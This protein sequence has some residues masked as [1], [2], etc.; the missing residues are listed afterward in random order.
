M[1]KNNNLKDFV[2][3]VANAIRNKKK[4][5]N[6]INPQD[7]ETEIETIQT[8]V[9]TS[10]ATATA[11]DIR[12][13]KTAYVASG[14]VTGTI[15]D[16]D[17]SSEPASGKSLFAQ[18]VD[19][20][21]TEVSASDLASVSMI[22][23]YAFAGCGSLTNVAI[24]SNIKTIG[25][26]AFKECNSLKSIAIPANVNRIGYEAFASCSSLQKII[27]SFG[28]T[29]IDSSAFRY[30]RSLTSILIPDSVTVMKNG[31]FEYC[32]S[33]TNVTLSNSITTIEDTTFSNCKSMQNII[34]PSGVISIGYGAFRSAGLTDITIPEGVT[35]I[36]SSAFADDYGLASVMIPSTMTKIDSYAFQNCGKNVESGIT[37]TVLATIPPTI[38]GSG[39]FTKT[40]LNKIIV[41][42]GTANTYKAATNWSAFADYIEE[43]TV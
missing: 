2:T 18:R 9:D 16:Y 20:S 28:V 37:F 34:I 40:Y 26:Y 31:M 6:L 38:V 43:A 27:I 4:T 41:P 11:D 33:L 17:G 22:S 25:S 39:V 36:G 3:G 10:D 23:S 1:A 32:T 21:L 8:G 13:D 29:T 30:N 24:P 35:T 15:E 42:A 5:T 14:K 19:G 7:F 12:A